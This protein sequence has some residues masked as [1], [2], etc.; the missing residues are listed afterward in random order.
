MYSRNNRWYRAPLTISLSCSAGTL[1]VSA[2]R[3]RARSP[4]LT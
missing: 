2:Y 3:R 4:S 1:L